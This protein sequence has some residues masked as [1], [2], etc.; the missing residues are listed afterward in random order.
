MISNIVISKPMR[1]GLMIGA[2]ALLICAPLLSPS[3]YILT[4]MTNA[5]IF[6][7]LAMSLNVIYGYTGL[8]S[9]AQVGFW[10][11]GAYITAVGAT[12]LGINP[13]LGCVIAM[14]ICAAVAT[15]LA[16]VSLR[17]SNHA[18]VIVSIAFTLLMQVLSQ[19]WISVTNGPMGI[20]GLP[21]PSIGFGETAF[22]FGT[23]PSYY[24][25]VLAV[26]V[27][28]MA[29]I[30]LVITSRI[31]RTL[32]LVK[33]DETLARS[34]GIRVTRWK[35]FSAAFS[36]AFAALA[37]TMNVFLLTIVDPS[38]FDV[39]YTQLMIVIAMV[40]GLG[41]FWPVLISG[42]VLTF[43]PELLRT[44]SELRMVNY[45]I[46]LMIVVVVFPRGVA[47]LWERITTIRSKVDEK[48]VQAHV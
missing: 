19:E 42:F 17:L 43:L 30:H 5:L 20:P 48:G 45:G 9:F 15:G 35:L 10:G 38:I 39:Y 31:G 11:M 21:A 33:H 44:S 16:A 32:T 40:G 47:G 29:V 4:V 1:G 14:I 28:T 26:F 23:L 25:L 41:T 34:Y 22:T 36:A 46:I 37:G 2:L 24:L 6:T 3:S 7:I 8:L 18:F 13:W 27:I 12:K